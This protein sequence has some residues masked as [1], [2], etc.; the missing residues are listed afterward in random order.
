MVAL[1]VRTNN[2]RCRMDKRLKFSDAMEIGLCWAC[3]PTTK[4]RWKGD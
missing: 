1:E 3:D 4:C 2:K